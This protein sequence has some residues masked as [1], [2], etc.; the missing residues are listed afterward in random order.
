[1][2]IG[3]VSR[4][5]LW[6]KVDKMITILQSFLKLIVQKEKKYT[7]VRNGVA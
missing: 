2:Q 1:M 6:W 5:K 7:L 4:K 3:L